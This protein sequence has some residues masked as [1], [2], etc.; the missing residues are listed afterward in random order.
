MGDIHDF[1]GH[2]L[3]SKVCCGIRYVNMKI[4]I[5]IHKRVWDSLPLKLPMLVGCSCTTTGPHWT[6]LANR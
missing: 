6:L 4:L 1:K 3:R 5:R 2:E